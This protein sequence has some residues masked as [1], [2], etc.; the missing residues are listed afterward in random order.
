[1]AK[2]LG[3]LR[4]SGITSNIPYTIKQDLLDKIVEG[5]I[6]PKNFEVSIETEQGLRYL[7]ER[8]PNMKFTWTI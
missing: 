5:E 4:I 3:T 6:R 2:Q 8:N 1:M 7:E